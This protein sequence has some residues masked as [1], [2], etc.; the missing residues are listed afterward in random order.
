EDRFQ[1]GRW[2]TR[3]RPLHIRRYRSSDLE[4]CLEIYRLNE[5]GRFPAGVLDHYQSGLRDGRAYFVV[6]EQEG[7]VVATGGIQ[8]CEHSRSAL[9]YGLVHPK[10]QNSGIGTALLLARLAL[11]NLKRTHPYVVSIA[12]VESSLGFYERFGFKWRG[13]WKDQNQEPRPW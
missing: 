10:H 5:P 11:L 2:K 12:C 4:R 7:Q 8:H 1:P 3:L 6:V 9:C 13:I